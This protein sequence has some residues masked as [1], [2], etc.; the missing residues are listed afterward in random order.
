MNSALES[1]KNLGVKKLAI[2][3]A[4]GFILLVGLIVTATSVSNGSLSPIYT[5]LSLED[6]NKIVTELESK[7][8]RYE[9]AGNGTTVMVPSE[10]ML[11]LRLSFA[12]EGIPS[13]G[14]IIGNEIFDKDEKLG[15][16][17]FMQN[18]NQ[19]RAL[20]GELSRTIMAM[21]QIKNAR[22][23]L[24]IP[25]RELFQKDK[26]DPTASIQLT[27]TGGSSLGSGEVSAIKYL[28]A[29]AVPGL[30]PENITIVDSRGILLARGGG[31]P[32]DP[33]LAASSSAEFKAAYENKMQTRIEEMLEKYVGMGAVKAQVAADIN[34]DRTVTNSESYD[35]D[36]QVA[37]STQT[38]S[39]KEDSNESTGGGAAAKTTTV[40]NNLPGSAGGGDSGAGSKDAH[41]KT[42]EVTNYEIS[43]TTKNQISEAGNV[44]K[45][46][47]AVIVD[48]TYAEDP[49]T[50]EMVYKDRSP[51][52][53][54]KLTDLVKSAVGFDDKRG[55]VVTVSSLKFSPDF[56]GTH[57]K[58]SPL[59]FVKDD[60]Q[61]IIQIL[62][63]GL[64]A[65]MVILMVVRPL[66]KRA[67]EVSNSNALMATNAGMPMLSGESAVPQIAGPGGTSNVT[68]IAGGGQQNNDLGFD[69]GDDEGFS[70]IAGI[71][72]PSKSASLRTIN[73][74]MEK[75][76]EEAVS[77]IRNWLYGENA[78]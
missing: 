71:R 40:A 64:V 25:K 8:V 62:V 47:I 13:S 46:S 53:I 58:A 48:G 20:E 38:T 74:L 43:K 76:P 1:I 44:K 28:V 78:A 54:K 31:D 22:V 59:A 68:Q 35:P 9:L 26:I 33:A 3:G 37:R 16:S 10:Q 7:G 67:L 41:E 2:L 56:G 50:K 19:M 6:S 21:N 12:A 51:E 72:G 14:S 63:M 52:E 66:V 36:G 24:V 27:I 4:A 61:N 15:T 11:K 60:F 70:S 65:V 34:F 55:D 69:T 42:D 18:I 17:S 32:N 30:S 77:V 39:D 29:T 45:L 75:N 57:E 5:N 73:D 23:H 49:K